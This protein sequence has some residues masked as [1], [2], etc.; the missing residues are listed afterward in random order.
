[1]NVAAK[2]LLRVAKN[3]NK[4]GSKLNEF[5]EG[6]GFGVPA[7]RRVD[8]SDAQP[9]ALRSTASCLS[10]RDIAQ[11]R[12]VRSSRNCGTASKPSSIRSSIPAYNDIGI[13]EGTL[14]VW[15]SQ[16]SL[17]LDIIQSMIDKD[18]TQA[19]GIPVKASIL[20][21]TSKIILTNAT[22]DNPDV[23]LVD[24]LRGFPYAYALRGMLED[25]RQY[26]GFDELA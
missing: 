19:T 17:Y 3:P 6:S 22:N 23:V 16:S 4:I 1:M 13:D 26:E 2:Q 14:E 18:F 9:T 5:S 20:Q 10:R 8:S 25:L 11:S 7:D 15:V 24:R 12:T 21:N